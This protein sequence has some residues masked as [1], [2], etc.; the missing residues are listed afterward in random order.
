MESALSVNFSNTAYV[1]EIPPPTP[2]RG[3]FRRRCS[4]DVEHALWTSADVG[5]IREC[6]RT[7]VILQRLRGPREFARTSPSL[8][9]PQSG[10]VIPNRCPPSSL[11]F[12]SAD[13]RRA[14]AFIMHAQ[15]AARPGSEQAP[16]L[17]V[18]LRLAGGAAEILARKM[19]GRLNALT[20]HY[21]TRRTRNLS[22]T[23]GGWVNAAARLLREL[24]L[25]H[26]MVTRRPFRQPAVAD[27][28]TSAPQLSQRRHTRVQSPLSRERRLHSRQHIDG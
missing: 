28:L 23:D 21:P 10:Y 27:Q 1:N 13:P 25:P 7:A 3:R 2:L 16:S 5:L 9:V 22:D 12:I 14:L 6:L 4:E 15:R 18:S 24:T 26:Q 20:I 17:R 19:C 8:R 11:S